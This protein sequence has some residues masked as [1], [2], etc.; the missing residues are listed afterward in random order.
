MKKYSAKKK[1]RTC[2]KGG[3]TP[4]I[5]VS[6]MNKPIQQL[7]HGKKYALIYDFKEKTITK[8]FSDNDSV[9]YIKIAYKTANE[10][11]DCKNVKLIEYVHI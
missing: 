5:E 9:T 2:K 7:V 10:N 4:Q 1:R 3:T 11:P 8:F 6:F